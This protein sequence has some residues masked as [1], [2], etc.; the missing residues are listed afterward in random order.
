M[1]IVIR[2]PYSFKASQLIPNM[3]R[4]FIRRLKL[5]RQRD[6]IRAIP[7]DPQKNRIKNILIE[8]VSA[9]NNDCSFC[10]VNVIRRE[11]GIMDFRLFEKIITDLEKANWRGKIGLFGNNE[12]LLDGEIFGK[13]KL[14]R[15]RLPDSFHYILTNGKLLTRDKLILLDSLGL[16][17]IVVNNYD[18]SLKLLPN[19]KKLTAELK[20]ENFDLKTEVVVVLRKKNEVLTSRGGKAPNK[21]LAT[22]PYLRHVC[23]YPFFQLNINWRGDVPLCC[24]DVGWE[25]VVGNVSGKSIGDIWNGGRLNEARSILLSAGRK[26]ISICSKCDFFV[27]KSL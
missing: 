5:N 11:F 20:E 3:G 22:T 16:N 21:L 2:N 8:T 15:K 13:L 25:V 26:G 23:L 19:L 27:D 6:R 12:P 18:D 9:C 1:K 7:F 4:E 10:P 14:V 24:N 17:R